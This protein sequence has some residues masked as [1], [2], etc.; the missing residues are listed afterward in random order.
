MD[1]EQRYQLFIKFDTATRIPMLVLALAMVPLLLGPALVQLP[2]GMEEAFLQLDL[3]IWAA[4]AFELAVKTYLAPSR[5]AYLRQNWVDVLIVVLPMLRPLRVL[6]FVRLAVFMARATLALRQILVHHGL[7]YSLTV[8]MV[9][10]VF[11]AALVS[12]VERVPESNIQSFP[13]AVWW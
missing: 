3:F 6:R 12:I 5:M 13:E 11:C 1:K 9:V 8:G 7:A 10:I 2:P 4:F